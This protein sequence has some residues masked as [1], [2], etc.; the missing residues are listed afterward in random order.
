MEQQIDLAKKN[1][2][3]IIDWLI[4][5]FPAAFLRKEDK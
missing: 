1:K 5:N 3:M 2:L 4:E